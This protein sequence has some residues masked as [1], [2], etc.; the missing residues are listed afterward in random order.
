[1]AGKRVY[2]P[3]NS[4]DASRGV[5]IAVFL[6]EGGSVRSDKTLFVFNEGGGRLDSWGMIKDKRVGSNV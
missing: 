6:D 2:V 1:M 3:C 5:A 4:G